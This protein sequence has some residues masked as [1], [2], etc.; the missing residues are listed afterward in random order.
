MDVETLKRLRAG[1]KDAQRE[2]SR[3]LDGLSEGDEQRLAESLAEIGGEGERE[4][5][6]TPARFWS[7]LA[8]LKTAVDATPGAIGGDLAEIADRAAKLGSCENVQVLGLRSYQR[9]LLGHLDRAEQLLLEAFTVG[10]ECPMRAPHDP[11]IT[12]CGLE[13]DRRLAILEAALGPS[14]GRPSP[15][16]TSPRRV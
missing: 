11:E 12:A 5:E 7:D 15:C 1:D 10:A 8:A 13:L 6:D 3:W 9:R 14:G 16:A 4:E 2:L